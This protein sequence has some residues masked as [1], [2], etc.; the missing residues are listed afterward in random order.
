VEAYSDGLLSGYVFEQGRPVSVY[1]D[2]L[3]E[4]DLMTSSR[5]AY[6]FSDNRTFIVH[7]T[8]AE[9]FEYLFG[10][11]DKYGKLIADMI[12]LDM[13]TFSEGKAYVM[14][15]EVRGYIDTNGK[16]LFTLPRGIVGY[17][18]TEGLS[19]VSNARTGRFGYIDTTGKE[20]IPYRFFE[21]GNFHDGLARVFTSHQ[22]TGHGKF[23]FINKRGNIVITPTYD[24][25][26][27]FKEG[28]CFVAIPTTEN[29]LI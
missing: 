7:E 16:F 2:D 27:N 12:Y 8:N 9:R 18:F 24:E 22:P 1:Y 5:K 13:Q 10:I 19:P 3:G 6:P 4:V 25:T 21:G 20:V 14:N 11:V 15:N 17:G 23:G 28:L 29:D 26:S